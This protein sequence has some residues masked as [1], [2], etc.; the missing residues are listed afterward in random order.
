MGCLRMNNNITECMS[1]YATLDKPECI[2]DNSDVD[3]YHWQVPD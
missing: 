1:A 2:I 3:D